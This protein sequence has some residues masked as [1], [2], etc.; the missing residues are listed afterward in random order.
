MELPD[1]V[2]DEVPA[3]ARGGV[4]LLLVAKLFRHGSP[5]VDPETGG[6]RMYWRGQ[7]ARLTGASKRA[8][9]GAVEELVALGALRVHEPLRAGAA[10]GYSVGFDAPSWGVVPGPGCPGRGVVPVV[11]GGAESAPLNRE[12]GAENAGVQKMHGAKNA[13]PSNLRGAE[14]AH[15]R[16]PRAYANGGGGDLDP[17]PGPVGVE[18]H[19]HPSG[20]PRE[21]ILRTLRG[22]GVDSPGAVLASHGPDRL[23][24]ALG[25]LAAEMRRGRVWN[26]AGWLVSALVDRG[27]VFEACGAEVLDE[28]AGGHPAPLDAFEA[29]RERYLGGALGHLV[30]WRLEP[31]GEVG[32]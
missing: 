30:R 12:G 9:D 24:G 10:R 1:W 20:D 18:I 25:E 31:S 5:L 16:E 2:V 17:I 28:V 11:A 4:P 29:E 19:H 14:N 22:L 3:R 32:R 8:L 21:Q 23:L 15:P 7:L 27:R 26:P 6:R 13:D